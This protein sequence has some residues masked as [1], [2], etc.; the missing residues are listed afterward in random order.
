MLFVLSPFRGPITEYRLALAINE[1]ALDGRSGT[2][3]ACASEAKKP[4]R[5]L[6]EDN[7]LADRGGGASGGGDDAKGIMVSCDDSCTSGLCAVSVLLF[8]L[9]RPDMDMTEGRVFRAR[10]EIG[11]AVSTGEGE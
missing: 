8:L 11:V 1:D 4:D 2:V 9:D 7:L 3:I 5:A 10:I 6:E